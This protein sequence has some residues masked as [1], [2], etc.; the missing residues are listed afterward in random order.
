MTFTGTNG[1]VTITA[2]SNADA[3]KSGSIQLTCAIKEDA[4]SIVKET[5]EDGFK[6]TGD[7][8]DKNTAINY[9]GTWS[10]WAGEAAEHSPGNGKGTKTETTHTWLGEARI[11]LTPL[12]EQK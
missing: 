10:N 12:Q 4:Q 9:V 1:D 8:G 11:L 6:T 5:V 7:V 2:T 3:T